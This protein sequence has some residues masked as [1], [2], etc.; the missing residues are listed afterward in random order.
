MGLIRATVGAIGSTLRDQWKEVIACENMSNEI[1][2]EMKTTKDGTISKGSVVR[3]QEGQCAA[4][5]QNGTVLDAVAEPGDYTF[6]ASATPSFFAGQFKDVF[7]EMWSRFTY[8]GNIKNSQVVFFFDTKEIMDNKFGTPTPV[9]YTDYTYGIPNRMTG[10]IMPLPLTV[11]CYG[12]YTFKITDPASFMKEVAGTA[13][14]YKKQD[15]IAQIRTEVIDVLETMLN[16]LGNEDN[17]IPVMSLPSSKEKIK[18]LLKEKNYDEAVKRRGISI[19]EVIIESISLDEKSKEDIENYKLS[20][21]TEMQQ[22]TLVG[23]YAQAVKDAANNSN[24]AANG[25]MGIGMMNMV[26]GGATGAVTTGPWQTTNQ[27]S[28]NPVNTAESNIDT[29]NCPKCNKQVSGNFCPECGSKKPEK[30]FCSNCGKPVQKDAKFCPN[31]GNK[32]N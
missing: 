11:K 26:S 30:A 18:E 1:L 27:Q 7:K 21:S 4:I 28:A 25:F 17:K 22:G 19:L 3:V 16:E 8:G 20:A 14:I 2:M 15:L 12:N 10:K 5:Y 24:G 29:W 6:D 32:I 9:M 31:C 23:S 13:Q